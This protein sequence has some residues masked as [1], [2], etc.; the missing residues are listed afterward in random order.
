MADDVASTC[1]SQGEA[2]AEVAGQ[3]VPSMADALKYL[4]IILLSVPGVIS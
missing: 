4:L 1:D 3:G 2:G